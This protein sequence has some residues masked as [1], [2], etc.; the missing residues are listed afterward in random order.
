MD[1]LLSLR[2][3]A[4]RLNVS[5]ATARRLVLDGQLRG[6]KI[7]RIHRVSEEALPDY[8]SVTEVEQD[9]PELVYLPKL[10]DF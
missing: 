3:V 1:A 9:E 2:D 5:Y 4:S 8:L 10:R 7:G 6:H